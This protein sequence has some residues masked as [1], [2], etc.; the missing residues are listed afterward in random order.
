VEGEEMIADEFLDATPEPRV[1]CWFSC[2]VTSAVAT[3]LMAQAQQPHPLI[4]AYTEVNEEHPDNKRFLKDCE[5]WFGREVV[6]L[7]NEKYQAS[8]Y[9]V[10]RRERY[11][12]GPFGAPC[13]KHLKRNMR[14]SFMRP[15][16]IHVLGFS[17]E[18]KSRAESF[19][20]NNPALTC[21]F[22]LIERG[23]T[24]NDCLALV[25]AAGIE[26]PAMYALGYE[27]NNCI[28][29]VKGGM[30]YWNK[31]R[32]DFPETFARMAA[33]E[34]QIGATINR[35][36]GVSVYLDELDPTAGR[37]QKEPSIECG[38]F[39]EQVKLELTK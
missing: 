38:V 1:L 3:K 4:V 32:V 15:G 16:D 39:C 25:N 19:E 13:T 29:C 2:G 6:I 11:L 22:P 26:L 17:T 31:I 27:H 7:R 9:E 14:E 36:K 23:L 10:F 21:R 37:G 18:E 33:T 24:K 20:E 12:V 5:S 8:I 30:G 35:K 34:R 28:G